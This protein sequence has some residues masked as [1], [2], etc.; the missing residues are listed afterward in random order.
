MAILAMLEHGRDAR[1]TPQE[2]GPRAMAILAMLEH[3]RDARGTMPTAQGRAALRMARMKNL[4]R[5]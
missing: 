5:P 2:P 4:A 1:G 3:G